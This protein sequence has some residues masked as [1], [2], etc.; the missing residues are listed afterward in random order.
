MIAANCNEFR[1]LRKVTFLMVHIFKQMRIS[2]AI[3]V[4]LTHNAWLSV[5]FHFPIYGQ[6][7]L[8]S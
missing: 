5:K 4:L 6:T 2:N 3:I 8:S 1:F 7:F